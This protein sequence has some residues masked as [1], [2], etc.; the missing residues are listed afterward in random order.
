[1][2][3]ILG[4]KIFSGIKDEL[5]IETDRVNPLNKVDDFICQHSG[6]HILCFLS[7]DLKNS[8]E[9]LYSDNKDH[10][11]FPIIKCIIPS[12]IESYNSLDDISE[13]EQT[14]DQEQI[15]FEPELNKEDYLTYI[16][17]IKKH[18]QLGDIYETNFCYQ[19][20]SKAISFNGLSIFKKLSSLTEA[21]FSIY[22]NLG[23][24]II[25]SASPERFI[26]KTGN[27]LL[28]QPI[29]GTAKRGT[30]E[31]EDGYIIE[32]L[33]KD[34]KER[35]ENIMIVDLVRND[36]SKIAV[37]NSV[38]VDNLCSVHTFKNIHQMISDVSC[39][40]KKGTL[41]S[42]VIKATFPMGSMTGVPK[43]KAMELMEKYESSKRGLY[44]GSIGL[45]SP[46]GDFDM[47]VII[48]TLLYNK[49]NHCLSFSVGGAITM[50]SDPEKEYEETLTKASSI[51][52]A[53]K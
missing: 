29:K 19:W 49:T 34:P 30:D 35:T 22:A 6:E 13:K 41:F 4:N 20:N 26:K 8:I 5:T 27:K 45:I 12:K 51:L 10:I 40:I 37:K 25:I 53:C 7:Y 9:E 17:K 39:E 42:D 16:Q 38:K 2:F 23:N 43:I 21:P 3:V 46:N 24:H 32:Q 11:Q 31:N 52:E 15:L 28:S 18:I 47:N 44:S 1:M 50:E 36:L 48:R 14:S 33:K